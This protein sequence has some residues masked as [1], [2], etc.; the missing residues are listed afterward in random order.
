MELKIEVFLAKSRR[1]KEK[2]P[3]T[4]PFCEVSFWA[5]NDESVFK[6]NLALAKG[7]ELQRVKIL[8]SFRLC[9]KLIES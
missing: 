4:F 9:E 8:A 1:R 6:E 2:N 5:G 7:S 3:S